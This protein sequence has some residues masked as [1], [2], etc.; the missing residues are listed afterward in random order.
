M[1]VLVVQAGDFDE[2]FSTLVGVYSTFDKAVAGSDAYCAWFGKPAGGFIVTPL[3]TD[4]NH[5]KNCYR[6]KTFRLSRGQVH[7]CWLRSSV[8]KDRYAADPEPT[9]VGDNA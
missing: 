3:L 8:F 9:P 4:F 7:N 1:E 5:T 6:Y 2:D